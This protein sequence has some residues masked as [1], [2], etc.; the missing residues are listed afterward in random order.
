MQP[1]RSS[2]FRASI[3][4]QDSGS[5]HVFQFVPQVDECPLIVVAEQGFAY[6][7]AETFALDNTIVLEPYGRIE[8]D[9]YV[10]TQP[11]ANRTI[12]VNYME[13]VNLH[14][15]YSV[16]TDAEGR[17]VFD[18]VVPGRVHVEQDAIDSDA[19]EEKHFG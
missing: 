5:V 14:L 19:V 17:F 18:K 4:R 9:F 15:A 7:T 1:A 3:V 8:G 11:G 13:G 2:R 12:H 16:T 6:V 10:G